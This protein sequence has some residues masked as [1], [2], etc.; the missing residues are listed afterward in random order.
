MPLKDSIKDFLLSQI[1][2]SYN[3]PSPDRLKE[4]HSL[5]KVNK[6]MNKK[7]LEAW[8][9][10][11]CSQARMPVVQLV[12]K[13]TH[14]SPHIKKV[15][16]TIPKR[17]LE[18]LAK[19]TQA[20]FSSGV[21]VEMFEYTLNQHSFTKPFIIVKNLEESKCSDKAFLDWTKALQKSGILD[22]LKA[23]F[24]QSRV[25]AKDYGFNMD[26][27]VFEFFLN[28]FPAG[29]L[30]GMVTHTDDVATILAF[31]LA[32]TGKR[33]EN[34]LF[35]VD[36]AGTKHFVSMESGD[37][38]SVPALVL[39]GVEIRT[40]KQARFTL[41]CF[42]KWAKPPAAKTEVA[43]AAKPAA[44]HIEAHAE[45]ESKAALVPSPKPNSRRR[46]KRKSPPSFARFRKQ[47]SDAQ[48][49]ACRKRRKVIRVGERFQAIVPEYAER[50][51]QTRN[52][53]L[54]LGE[55]ELQSHRDL[56]RQICQD[57]RDDPSKYLDTDENWVTSATT[58]S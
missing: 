15:E 16:V 4:L 31:V 6:H 57:M 54:Q 1:D 48:I 22:K 32:L 34:D 47:C 36:R 46:T 8:F 13:P 26:N 9:R 38:V 23:S 45:S 10:H 27:Y 20:L 5:K 50:P 7:Q 40:R 21:G 30:S 2:G 28:H 56:D 53:F 43:P 18:N 12:H 19:L 17:F 14:E 52:T 29:S 55:D 41:N 58:A 33:N 49:V 24:L 39:H 25:D 42:V 44:V 51:L 35:E 11:R 37:I 3:V